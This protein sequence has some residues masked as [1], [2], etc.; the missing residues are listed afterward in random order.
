[1]HVKTTP[2]WRI[3]GAFIAFAAAN[4]V[5]CGG[6]T[7]NDAPARISPANVDPVAAAALG[8]LLFNDPNLS[9][10][11]QQSCATC[12]NAE[13]GFI[14]NRPNF[15]NSAVSLG[16]DD[17]SLGTRNAPT[18][19]YAAFIPLFAQGADGQYLGGQFHDGRAKN[20]G[21]QVNLNGGPILN[22]VEM[23]MPDQATV[24]A[25]L[26]ENPDYVAKFTTLFGADVF[27]RND[28]FIFNRIGQ[29][30]AA[31]EKTALFSPF[32][33]K[34]DR[35]LQSAYTLTDTE[36]LGLQL[37]N[38]HCVQ[39]HQSQATTGVNQEVFSNF[40]YYNLGVPNH[41][42]VRDAVGD[43][44]ADPGLMGN[45]NVNND[46]LLAGKFKTPTLRNVAITGPYMH[47]GV[48]QDLR[49]VLQFKD[50]RRIINNAER[51][52]NPETGLAWSDTDYTDTVDYSNAP[53]L[54]DSDIDALMAFLP[55]LTDARY[56][57]LLPGTP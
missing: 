39:C 13:H 3:T 31:Y 7:T 8:E 50:H 26:Q 42:A 6:G 44:S 46:P 2:K 45:P 17:A 48:F 52:I 12:H 9:L 49:T 32:D 25:R 56:E 15:L 51:T 30:I 18:V 28:T 40:K 54:S 11:R 22:P 38:Q 23:M 43:P 36:T 35:Y 10:T 20:L 24:I 55:L 33:S 27:S 5:G 16:D 47:N 41:Q 29:S 21:A 34:Y 37:F 19:A 57:A 1:M 53:A 4:L 14:D